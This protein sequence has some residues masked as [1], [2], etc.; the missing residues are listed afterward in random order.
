L[1][2]RPVLKE[3]FLNGKYQFKVSQEREHPADCGTPDFG[4][5]DLAFV[6]RETATD[7]LTEKRIVE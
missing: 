2:T 3:E 1:L 7:Y 5:T 6:R 4:H